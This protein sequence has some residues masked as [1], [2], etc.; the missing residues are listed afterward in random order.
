MLE[1][2][3]PF[4][5]AAISAVIGLI[6]TFVA[7]KYMSDKQA[8]RL[9]TTIQDVLEQSGIFHS[10]V[11]EKKDKTFL[12]ETLQE[13]IN[14]YD[15]DYS[16]V[17]IHYTDNTYYLPAKPSDMENIKKLDVLDKLPYRPERFDSEDFSQTFSVLTSFL[18]GV[19]SVGT[20]IEYNSDESYN[21]I[22]YRD[23][24][25]EF[26]KSKGDIDDDH[27]LDRGVIIF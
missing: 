12:V 14:N 20:V 16:E 25:V 7:T 24:T 15:I 10:P 6:A 8:Q 22:V 5:L 11:V 21:I 13:E 4:A 17:D 2:I 23:G 19:N 3:P 9:E 18:F 26:Y 1:Q 27:S